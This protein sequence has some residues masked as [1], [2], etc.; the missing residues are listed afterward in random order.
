M[1]LGNRYR[2]F[3]HINYWHTLPCPL[4]QILWPAYGNPDVAAR[5][6]DG[7]PGR[8]TPRLPFHAVFAL[9][10]D[11]FVLRLQCWRRPN[12]P[13]GTVS[14]LRGPLYYGGQP[15]GD[16]LPNRRD[17]AEHRIYWW[18]ASSARIGS[19]GLT[20]TGPLSDSSYVQFFGDDFLRTLIL[21]FVFC[22]V[23]LRL[24]RSFRGRHQRPRCE[25]PLPIGELL[26]HP[27]LSHIVLQLATAL[28]A[29]GHF[30]EGTEADWYYDSHYLTLSTAA[31]STTTRTTTLKDSIALPV[32]TRRVLTTILIFI[33]VLLPVRWQDTRSP[34]VVVVTILRKRPTN[35]YSIEF[36]SFPSALRCLP[37][38]RTISWWVWDGAVVHVLLRSTLHVIIPLRI[39]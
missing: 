28:D 1:S 27:S 26:E 3:V 15:P 31:V 32:T 12:S 37:K 14:G 21:R 25:P 5:C 18:G 2:S 34:I 9:P 6:A 13:L 23:V 22:D 11:R 30:S 29:R 36:P 8:A 4:M 24:H 17:W 19:V 20:L 10:I 35:P 39:Q 7:V 38:L 16:A 33:A